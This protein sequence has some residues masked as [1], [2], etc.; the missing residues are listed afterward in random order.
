MSWSIKQ[1]IDE[2]VQLGETP[3]IEAKQA[4]DIGPSVMQTICA[5][6][7][8]PG[9]DGGWLLLGVS[10]PDFEYDTFWVSGIENVDKLLGELQNNCRNQFEHPVTI[11]C[12]HTKIEGK[13]VIGVFVHEFDPSAKPCRFIGKPDKH[14]KRKT[15]V[16]RRGANGDYECTERELEPILMAR[17][18]KSYEQI[19]FDDAEYN[20]LDLN[21]IVLYRKL[22]AQVKPNA[23]ELQSNDVNMLCSMRLLT[24]SKTLPIPN[25]AGLLLFGKA[26]S[27]RRLLPMVRVDYVRIQGTEWVENPEQRFQ[28]SI[29]LREPLIRLISKLENVILDDMPYHFRLEEGNL[30]RS[31]QPLLPQKVI[32]EGIVN[33]IMHRDYSVHQPII[34][35]RYRNRLEIHNPGYSLKPLNDLDNTRSQLR[36]PILAAVLYDLDFAETKGTGIRTMQRL[37]QQAG[38]TKPVFLSNRE[39]N[40]FTAT[41]LLHQLLGEEQLQWLQQFNHLNLSDDEAKALVLVK[42]MRAI[43]NAALRAVTDLDTLAASQVLRRLWQ[44]Y[45]L[46][47]KGGSGSTSYYKPTKQFQMTLLDPAA[48]TSDLPPYTSDL[49]SN[50]SDFPPYTSDLDSNTKEFSSSLKKAI[51]ALTPRAR[52]AQLWP[53]ILELCLQHA[54][55]AEQIAKL[56]K[57]KVTALKT[58]HLTPMRKEALINYLYPE[59]INH[60]EQAYVITKKGKQWLDRDSH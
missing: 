42:E 22:R 28:Y 11:E 25:I 40:Q 27:L 7:N 15:G 45:H 34:V 13:S 4:N 20:D 36:N 21:V 48:N 54:Y 51:D 46:I 16:W 19:T 9:L 38:L 24:K 39:S 14:N 59:V 50:T 5:F 18:G 60:P 44:Q 23:E 8:E 52:K 6:A 37:L 35:T 41:F 3:R 49:D 57:R 17:S 33:A 43:D 1:I 47:E 31:D 56:L 55:S 10:E 30:Q 58:G 32:R 12:K 2:L 26:S 29:D 53:I